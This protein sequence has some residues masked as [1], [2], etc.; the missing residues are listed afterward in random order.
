ML[1]ALSLQQKQ[2]GEA[3]LAPL[4]LTLVLS[5][6]SVVAGMALG[7]QTEASKALLVL[8]AIVA[9]KWVEAFSLGVSIVRAQLP[10]PAMGRLVGAFA[11]SSP[12][13]VALGWGLRQATEGAAA[14]TVTAVLDAAA[15]GTFIYIAVVDTLQEEFSSGGRDGQ[16]KF[17]AVIAGFAMMLWLGEATHAH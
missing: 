11:C 3:A 1:A 2:G 6:H 16:R 8:L 5:V 14:R 7:V 15:S 4:V 9:H 10:L 17:L 12:L 13:G